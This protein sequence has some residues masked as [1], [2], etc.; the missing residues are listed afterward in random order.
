MFSAFGLTDKSLIT[1]SSAFEGDR[2]VETDNPDE[3]GEII[4]N[5]P[6]FRLIL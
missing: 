1:R 3:Y 2:C 6:E 5:A 4:E